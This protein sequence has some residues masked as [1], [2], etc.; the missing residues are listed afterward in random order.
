MPYKSN[1]QRRWAHSP[2]GMKELG[3]AKVKEFDSATKGKKL[4]EKKITKAQPKK[5]GYKTHE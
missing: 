1:A 3:A 4:P 5:K 2:T